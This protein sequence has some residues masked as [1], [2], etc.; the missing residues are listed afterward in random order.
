MSD[1]S[2]LLDRAGIE[3]AFRRLGDRLARRGGEDEPGL[4]CTLRPPAATSTR[5]S[6]AAHVDTL[7]AFGSTGSARDEFLGYLVDVAHDAIRW[8]RLVPVPAGGVGLRKQDE[9]VNT[10]FGVP[11]NR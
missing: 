7:E 4:R 9:A 11:V 8:D 5:E 2:P 1:P 3:D 6:V 10:Q